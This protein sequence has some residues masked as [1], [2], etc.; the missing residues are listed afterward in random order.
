MNLLVLHI[1]LIKI[2]I[3]FENRLKEILHIQGNITYT[4]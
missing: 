2:T 3:K 1:F 4:F